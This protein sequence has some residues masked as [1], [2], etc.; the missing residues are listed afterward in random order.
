MQLLWQWKSFQ[1]LTDPAVL[2]QILA[3]RQQIFI[4]EQNCIYPDIDGQDAAALHLLGWATD[5]AQLTLVAYARLFLP[6]QADEHL[7]FGRVVVGSA[8]R[9]RR[10][11]GQL[12]EQIL[13]YIQTSTYRDKPITISAQH[14]L[15]KFY[16]Q[17]NFKVVGEP[18]DEDGIL[19]VEMRRDKCSKNL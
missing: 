14:Y 17:F 16:Q 11:G 13:N 5:T 3:L 2:Y 1:D 9:G 8:F 18:Y 12:V 7:S 19:H 6:E 10:L 4:I 15:V